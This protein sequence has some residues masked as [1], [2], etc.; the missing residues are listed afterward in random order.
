MRIFN[1][2]S[3]PFFIIFLISLIGDLSGKYFPDYPQFI[4]IIFGI[5]IYL[6][7]FVLSFDLLRINYQNLNRLPQLILIGL[8]LLGFGSILTGFFTESQLVGNRFLTLFFNPLFAPIFILP[9]YSIY[10][11]KSNLNYIIQYI[12]VGVILTSL[13]VF[14][15]GISMDLIIVA[16]IIFPIVNNNKKFIIVLF[17]LLCVYVNLPNVDLLEGGGRKLLICLFFFATS[18][19][20]VFL[21]KSRKALLFSSVLVSVL[22]FLILFFSFSTGETIF[23]KVNDYFISNGSVNSYRSDDTRTFLYLELSEDLS[24]NDA[25]LFGKGAYS[26]YYS[27]YFDS[28]NITDGDVAQRGAIEVTVLH[29]I[30]KGGLLY[31]F[32]LIFFIQIAVN[33]AIFHSKN[34]WLAFVAFNINGYYFNIFV[35]DLNGFD[36]SSVCIWFFIGMCLN[37]YWLNLSNKELLESLRFNKRSIKYG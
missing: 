28:Q 37:K 13:I 11:S 34:S 9:V 32:L 26:S 22:P 21:F 10:I 7:L 17:S 20:V 18:Y 31:T 16:G 8:F 36:F 1:K 4:K 30:L 27:S 15:H 14:I 3:L 2:F 33:T 29:Y 6:S 35:G 23:Q 19:I 24:N 12:I 5:G 25:W